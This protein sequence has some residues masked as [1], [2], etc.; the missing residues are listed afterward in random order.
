MALNLFAIDELPLAL[1]LSGDAARA[2]VGVGGVEFINAVFERDLLHRGGHRAIIEATP[3]DREQ[4]GL[5]GDGEGP[6]VPF[7][8]CSSFSLTG[9]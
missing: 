8:Q 7:D 6:L 1:Q 5:D 3:A 9:R 4:L 2:V